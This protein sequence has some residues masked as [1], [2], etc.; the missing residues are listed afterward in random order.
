MKWEEKHKNLYAAV[1]HLEIKINQ[2]APEIRNYTNNYKQIPKLQE[3]KTRSQ[4]HFDLHLALPS[5][6]FLP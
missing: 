3:Q 5:L 1:L 4:S 2:R 6:I